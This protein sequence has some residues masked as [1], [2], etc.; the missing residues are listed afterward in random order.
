ML[1][2]SNYNFLDV[3]LELQIRS[4]DGKLTERTMS[5]P[6]SPPGLRFPNGGVV[7]NNFVVSGTYLTSSKQ[8]YALWA[9]D[10]RNLTWSRIDAGGAVFSQGSWNRGILWNRRNTFVILGHR[11][12][13]LVEDYNHRRI[14][15]SHVCMVE[16]EAFGLYD[17]PRKTSPTSRY[18]SV[19]SPPIPVS[20]QPKLASQTGGGRPYFS[21]AEKLGQTALSIPEIADMDLLA[22][23]GER[24]PVNS[25]ILSRRWGAY[26]IQLLKDS[27]ASNETG[28]DAATLRP[29]MVS[30]ASRNSNVTIT[31]SI[32]GASSS[33]STATTLTANNSL[34]GNRQPGNYLDAPEPQTLTPTSRP[35]TLYLPHNHQ[36][37]QLLIR[38]LYTS[39]LPPITSPL[40]TCQILCSLLQLARPYQIDGLLEAT[41]ERLH[42]VLDAR[43]AAAVFN[44][45][46]MAAGGGRGTG[47]NSGAGGTL[48]TLNEQAGDKNDRSLGSLSAKAA[49]LRINTSVAANGR[50]GVHG[51]KKKDS[52]DSASTSTSMSS[53]TDFS[54]T[55]ASDSETGGRAGE[56]RER[57]VWTGDISSVVGL[58]KRGLK[59]LMEGRRLR[60]RGGAGPMPLGANRGIAQQGG[61]G[62]SNAGPDAAATGPG[63]SRG[64]GIA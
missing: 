10:L 57:E 30:Q 4:P 9:L 61:N 64:L 63:G 7:N 59:G 22:M 21:A 19:S 16:L 3:K 60:E 25:H 51:H 40:C 17:N 48:Q 39:S 24:I 34:P 20:L 11:K 31:P 38:Y 26:F 41:V 13:S 44:A 55:T 23:G 47:M 62:T 37:I 15:F 50:S 53:N 28:S 52:L 46:A 14:N 43:N 6:V 2:Y 29:Q 5:G 49:G 32:S 36:T 8:E 56:A 1:I 42:Q 58:Q 35:R 54:T 18:I 33:Y 27:T 45:A 12:R